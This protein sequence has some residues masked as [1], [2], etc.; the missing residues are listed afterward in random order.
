MSRLKSKDIFGMHDDKKDYCFS[1]AP[2]DG[3]LPL[4]DR[5]FTDDDVIICD[6]CGELIH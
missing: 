1:C 3:V 2:V 6:E 4:L 5:D